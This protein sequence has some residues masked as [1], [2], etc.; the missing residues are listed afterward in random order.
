MRKALQKIASLSLTALLV[1]LSFG[2]H[3]SATPRVS[4]H[5]MEGV[6]HNA[7]SSSCAIICTSATL[8][9][10]ELTDE[11]D[12]EK[13]DKDNEPFYAHLQLSSIVLLEKEHE[14][15]TKTVLKHEPPPGLPAYVEL[16]VYRA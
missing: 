8:H 11:N 5:A 9:K 13:D 15:Q 16:G 3:A 14:T 6:N 7:S 12:E 2:I 4:G 1:A 10:E